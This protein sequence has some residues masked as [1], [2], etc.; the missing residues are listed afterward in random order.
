MYHSGLNV[1]SR[2]AVPV[3]GGGGWE[4]TSMYALYLALSFAMNPEVL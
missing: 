4:K 3:P 1:D 2:E